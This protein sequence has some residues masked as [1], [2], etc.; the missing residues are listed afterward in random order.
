MW[1]R[2]WDLESPRGTFA[3]WRVVGEEHSG[4]DLL[5]RCNVRLEDWWVVYWYRDSHERKLGHCEMRITDLTLRREDLRG[6]SQQVRAWLQ[7]PLADLRDSSIDITC[8][9]GSSHDNRL[10]LVV[11]REPASTCGSKPT[12]RLRYL[13]ESLSGEMSFEVNPSCLRILVDGIDRA[14]EVPA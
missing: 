6:L 1:G 3:R 5:I 2:C 13:I 14:L 11:R 10:T 12:A 8:D 7:L 9:M 4:G